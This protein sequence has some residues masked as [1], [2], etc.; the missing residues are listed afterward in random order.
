MDIMNTEKVKALVEW[1][2]TLQADLRSLR[3]QRDE[4]ND[5]ISK[6]ETQARNLCELLES[7]GYVMQ[8]P[9]EGRKASNGSVA[10]EAYKLVSEGGQPIYYKDIA[11]RL[12]DAG[13]SIPGRD[14]Q[15]NLLSYIARDQRFRRIG[16]GMY[17]LT[18]WG[19]KPKNP[20]K[21]SRNRRRTKSQGKS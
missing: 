18:E 21:S 14:P 16:R 20:K 9:G 11:D 17:S 13:V 8:E 4:L 10:D 7:E 1:N 12:I 15:A 19:L 5:T 3:T 2:E 6:K